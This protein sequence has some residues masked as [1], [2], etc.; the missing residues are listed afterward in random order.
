MAGSTPSSLW[1]GPRASICSWQRLHFRCSP[2]R[3]W[4]VWVATSLAMK[5]RFKETHSKD[6]PTCR[7]SLTPHSISTE[8]L[9]R[10]GGARGNMSNTTLELQKQLGSLKRLGDSELLSRLQLSQRQMNND[11]QRV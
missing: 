10:I 6:L 8:G 9:I 11:S 7:S 3:F 2:R 4:L 5:I 1:F